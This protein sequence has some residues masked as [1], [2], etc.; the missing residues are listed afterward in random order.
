MI[1][2]VV[3]FVSFVSIS[4]F[5]SLPPKEFPNGSVFS[6]PDGYPMSKVAALLSSNNIIKSEFAFKA[7]LTITGNNTNIV[8]G[9][10]RLDRPES[11]VRIAFRLSNGQYGFNR[12]KVTIPEGSTVSDIAK[13]IASRLASSSPSSSVKAFDEATF[14]LEAKKYEGKL[15]PD[16]YF[17][18]E[19]V[20]PSDVI[21]E[22]NKNYVAKIK[23]I[24]EK[25]RLFNRPIEEIIAMAS[26]IEKESSSSADRKTI[27]GILWKR[28][29]NDMALQVDPPF[30]YFLNKTSDQLTLDDL[31]IKSPYNLYQNRGLPPTPINNPG[32][33]AILDTITPTTSKYWFYLSDKT[34]GMHYAST[35]D[36]HL[37]N[38]DRYL[39]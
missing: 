35:Y 37:V 18:Y 6:V 12:I 9:D 32:L 24:E 39:R 4:I 34:G 1:S 23:E 10:Y 15:F 20:K 7:L 22:M 27:A 14:E 2:A 25:I 5:Y 21:E 38:K 30:Y 11:V 31:A 8:K 33:S 29:D 26:I 19:N 13:I 16:T 28:M 17:F 3:L 36:L